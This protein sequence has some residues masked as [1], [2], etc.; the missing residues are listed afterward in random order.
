MNIQW[1]EKILERYGQP[2]TIYG[3]EGEVSARAFLQPVMENQEAEPFVM[4]ELGSIDDRLWRYLG[5]IPLEERDVV[6]HDGKRFSVRSCRPYY[7][8]ETAIYWWAM[9]ERER[10]AAQ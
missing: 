1:I 7:V 2:V 9:L 5:R 4:T 10:E 6:A 3:T 8:G